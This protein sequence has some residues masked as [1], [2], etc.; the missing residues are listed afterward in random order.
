[1]S[2]ATSWGARSLSGATTTLRKFSREPD[3]AANRLKSGTSKGSASARSGTTVT[4]SS[5]HARTVA[6]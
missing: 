2:P 1:M 4:G 5:A 3:A 6:E